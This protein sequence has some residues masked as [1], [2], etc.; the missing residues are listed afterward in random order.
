MYIVSGS[1][2]RAFSLHVMFLQRSNL[3]SFP[4]KLAGAKREFVARFRLPRESRTKTSLVQSIGLYV[5]E[6]ARGG[7][8][9]RQRRL[10]YNRLYPGSPW[11]ITESRW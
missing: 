6:I 4:R 3:S 8:L 2:Y 1:I 11:D 7:F 9:A 10:G 5:C